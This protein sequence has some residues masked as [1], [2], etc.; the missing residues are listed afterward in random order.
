MDFRSPPAV[1]EALH[2]RTEHGI[3]GYTEAPAELSE[4]I[5]TFMGRHYGWRV[6]P[7]WLVWL[8]GLVSGLNVACRAVGADGDEVLTTTP[9]YPPFLSAPGNFRRRLCTVPLLHQPRGWTFDWERLEEAITGRTRLFLLCSPHNPVGRVF[10]REELE[11]LAFFCLRH[12]LVICSD[13]IHAGLILDPDKKHLPTASLSREVARR[14]ITLLAPSKT[15][16]IPGLGFSFAVISDPGLR[17]DFRQAMAGIVPEV[18]LFGFIAALAAYQQGGEWLLALL[19]YLRQNRELVA[20]AVRAM[21]GLTASRVEA[22]YLAWIDTRGAGIDKPGDFFEAAGVGLSDGNQ[23]GG[24]GFV[25]LNFGCPRAI[26]QQAL[27]RM[28]QALII[29]AEKR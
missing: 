6:H 29:A 28:H 14:T 11:R 22:T 4:T 16:N 20:E 21:P 10:S 17:G 18:N 2:R 13:E 5:V 23:F 12:D 24:P 7:E 27:S 8:P 15:Y 9:V 19:A 26:L 3:F 1:I 25:R